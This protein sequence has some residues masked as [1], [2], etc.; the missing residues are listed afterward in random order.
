MSDEYIETLSFGSGKTIKKLQKIENIPTSFFGFRATNS[1]E[2]IYTSFDSVPYDASSAFVIS[3][4]D[5]QNNITST[6]AIQK[7]IRE[8]STNNFTRI[9]SNSF[10]LNYIGIGTVTYQR[11]DLKLFVY[12]SDIETNKEITFDISTYSQPIE[13][14]PSTGKSAMYQTTVSLTGIPVEE[15]N[16]EVTVDVSE[17]SDN[18]VIEITPSAGNDVMD[19]VSVELV[20]I[21][22]FYAWQDPNA[23]PK[24]YMY[25]CF[26]D[27]EKS[28]GIGYQCG[29]TKNAQIT[30]KNILVSDSGGLYVQGYASSVYYRY[31]E[32]DL[33]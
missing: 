27:V 17:Y 16:K 1:S 3:N 15:A 30:Q 14:N 33:S 6:E 10:S 4:I 25:T 28:T 8:N 5:D 21:P 12:D 2:V 26:D 7:L 22:K 20:H 18:D 19:K 11:A 9:S 24:H 31:P 13:I 23:S 32:G 29:T